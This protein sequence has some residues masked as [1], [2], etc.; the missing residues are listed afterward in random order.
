MIESTK[1]ASLNC[2][3]GVYELY[4]KSSGLRYIGRSN[5][6]GIRIMSHVY[7]LRNGSHDN[8]KLQRD[9]S[10]F[11]EGNFTYRVLYETTS[12]RLMKCKEQEFIDLH[13]SEGLY[14]KHMS[15]NTGA[16]ANSISDETR[17]KMSDRQKGSANHFHGKK[18]SP[19][20][21]LRMRESALKRV[22][23]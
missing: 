4:C 1:V 23:K 15:S 2:V 5:A 11:S 17:R 6:I 16:V 22:R 21:L 20:T 10:I 18:H 8:Q 13:K 12:L 19:E 9:F 3:S 14:N 7:L